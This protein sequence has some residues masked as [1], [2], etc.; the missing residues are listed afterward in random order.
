[1]E[2]IARFPGGERSVESLGPDKPT[3]LYNAPS[4]HT[5]DNCAW[6]HRACQRLSQNV[7]PLKLD[8]LENPDGPP[9]PTE[10]QTPPNNKK[11]NSQILKSSRS[12]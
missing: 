3:W 8:I 12:P 5:V 11:R 1:M 6:I 9:R 7:T 4:S 2:K 10:P